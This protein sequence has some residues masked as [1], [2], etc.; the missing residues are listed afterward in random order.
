MPSAPAATDRIEHKKTAR[1]NLLLEGHSQ[2]LP[3][4]FFSAA[5]CFLIYSDTHPALLPF[6]DLRSHIC[7]VFSKIH[8]F[9]IITYEVVRIWF[10]FKD[11]LPIL[12]VKVQIGLNDRPNSFFFELALID[13]ERA[14]VWQDVV[15]K[16]SETIYCLHINEYFDPWDALGTLRLLSMSA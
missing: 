12:F 6:A 7:R 10:A 16:F 8:R 15:N 2:P 3:I 4:P 11:F 9:P 5:V 13:H 1:V 14:I